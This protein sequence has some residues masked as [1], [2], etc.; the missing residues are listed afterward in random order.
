MDKNLDYQ[1]KREI[2]H[3]ILYLDNPSRADLIQRLNSNNNISHRSINKVSS[4][5]GN[6]L[7]SNICNTHSK[8]TEEERKIERNFMLKNADLAAE[9]L[10]KELGEKV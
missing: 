8:Y 1:E 3:R 4:T 7:K 9:H 6:S 10:K 2:E 5:T